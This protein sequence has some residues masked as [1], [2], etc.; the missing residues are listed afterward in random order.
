MRIEVVQSLSRHWLR[1]SEILKN[2]IEKENYPL[3]TYEQFCLKPLVIFETFDISSSITKEFR[4]SYEVAVNDYPK[5]KVTNMNKAQASRLT[6]EEKEA[7]RGVLE[8]QHDI[9]NFFGYALDF[10]C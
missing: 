7:I 3:L 9:V 2:I 5:Q 1:R 4:N 8:S 10:E 6:H